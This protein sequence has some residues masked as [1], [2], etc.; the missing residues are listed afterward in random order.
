MNTLTSLPIELYPVIF[1]YIPLRDLHYNLSNTC[2]LFHTIIPHYIIFTL[3]KVLL[4][5]QR[6]ANYSPKVSIE[7]NSLLIITLV[8]KNEPIEVYPWKIKMECTEI[9]RVIK[10]LGQV[11]KIIEKNRAKSLERNKDRKRGSLR[12]IGI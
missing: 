8:A 3:N 10:M 4:E 6:F 9:D 11:V 12:W 1:T 7:N 2:K 5:N